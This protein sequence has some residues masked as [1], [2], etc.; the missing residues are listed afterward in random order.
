MWQKR[1]SYGFPELENKSPI[2]HLVPTLLYHLRV[3]LESQLKKVDKTLPDVSLTFKNFFG[4]HISFE[5]TLNT[6]A[7]FQSPDFAQF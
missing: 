6:L 7:D 2:I 1:G 5:R 4:K 3:L